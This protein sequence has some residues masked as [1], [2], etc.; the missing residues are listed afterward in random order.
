MS[1]FFANEEMTL[2]QEAAEPL[3]SKIGMTCFHDND[4][5]PWQFGSESPTAGF[6][7]RSVFF[8][9]ATNFRGCL[10]SVENRP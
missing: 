6:T 5:M 1:L 3:P 10:W 2:E 8:I 7:Q 9:V 4:Y